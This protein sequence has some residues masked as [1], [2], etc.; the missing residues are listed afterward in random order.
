MKRR[1][2]EA[3][4]RYVASTTQ[5]TKTKVYEQSYDNQKYACLETIKNSI[6]HEFEF[7]KFQSYIEFSVLLV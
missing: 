4:S 5:E 3:N 7:L 1:R 6:V 2:Q